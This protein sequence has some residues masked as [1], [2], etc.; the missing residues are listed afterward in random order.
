MKLITG[1]DILPDSCIKIDTKGF[2][3]EKPSDTL[4][5]EFGRRYEIVKRIN[6]LHGICSLNEFYVNFGLK[7]VIL[8][9][10]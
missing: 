2:W 5:N 10:F 6:T 9:C 7:G 8:E 1:K 4:G 3:K